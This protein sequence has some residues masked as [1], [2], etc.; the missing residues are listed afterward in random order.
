MLE[1]GALRAKCW[2]SRELEPRF[3][4]QARIC[5]GVFSRTQL[6]DARMDRHWKVLEIQVPIVIDQDAPTAVKKP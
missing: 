6:I 1:G 2:H 5:L 4:D 3:S